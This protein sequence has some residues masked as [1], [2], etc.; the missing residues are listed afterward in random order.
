M[1]IK[2]TRQQVASKCK[3][4]FFL[5]DKVGF[6]IS[7]YLDPAL[8]VVANHRWNCDV[9]IIGN[10]VAL[11]YGDR[12]IGGRYPIDKQE[13]LVKKLN[14]LESRYDKKTIKYNT[15]KRKGREIINEFFLA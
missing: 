15:M 10:S 2:A 4:V 6:E 7:C 5:K 9:F 12:Y 11:T 13:E 14:K 1:K 3:K 8:C